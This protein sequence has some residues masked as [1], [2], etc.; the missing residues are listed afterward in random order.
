M[1]LLRRAGVTKR[2]GG[3]AALSDVDLAVEPGEVVGLIGENGAGKS[4]LIKIVAGAVRPDAGE[5]RVDD[6]PVAFRTPRDAIAAGIAVIYQELT[7]CPDLDAVEN[8]LLGKLP[9]RGAL[10]DWPAARREAAR[11]LSELAADTPLDV[12]LRE[13]SVGM[14]Q[15]VEI[16]RALSRKS[17][18]IFMDEPTASLS[19]RETERLLDIVRD[20]RRRD[21]AVGF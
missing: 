16:A 14:Q 21:V 3:V 15:L 10:V 17:R 12:P 4:T 20:P 5:M 7:T 18:L 9:A 8:V 11:W 2:Y 1:A 6:R 13:M 19:R